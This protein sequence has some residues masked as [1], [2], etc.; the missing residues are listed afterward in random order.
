MYQARRQLQQPIP[1]RRE[2]IIL[3]DYHKLTLNKEFL[4]HQEN[5]FI[6]FSTD[7]NLRELSTSDKV[8]MD[9]TFKTAQHD[10]TQPQN[11]PQTISW[12]AMRYCS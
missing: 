10:F 2:D 7:Q 3:T 4:Q 11:A 6:I 1:H 9:G 8:Y 5:S 12:V